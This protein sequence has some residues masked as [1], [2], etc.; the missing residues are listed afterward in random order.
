MTDFAS[1]APDPAGRD[2]PPPPG[3]YAWT[4]EV[5]SVVAARCEECGNCWLWK[6]C[7]SSDWSD[8]ASPFTGLGARRA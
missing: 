2:E 4:P 3:A 8:L 1:H 5:V 6:Q 7:I